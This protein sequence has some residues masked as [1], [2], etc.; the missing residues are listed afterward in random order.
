MRTASPRAIVVACAAFAAGAGG[1]ALFGLG[2]LDPPNGPI[3]PTYKTMSEVEPRTAINAANTPGDADSRFK[4]T[5]PGSYYLTGNLTG[6][7][8]KSGIEVTANCTIDLCG[9]ELTGVNGSLD[10]I[11]LVGEFRGTIRNGQVVGWGGNGIAGVDCNFCLF[12][13]LYIQGNA[14]H[15][16]WIGRDS[17]LS[18]VRSAENTDGIRVDTFC[19]IVDSI[20]SINRDRGIRAGTH[21]TISRCTARG[22]VN[23]GIAVTD[24]A[25]VSDCVSVANATGIEAQ[26]GIIR[27]NVCDGNPNQNI[28][29]GGAGGAIVRNNT[30]NNSADTG[31]YCAGGSTLIEANLL[32]SNRVGVV[33]LTDG[34][35][36]VIRNHA[37]KN[38]DYGYYSLGGNDLGQILKNP[39]HLFVSTNS[40]ANIERQ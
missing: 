25:N 17:I 39:G 1:F 14:A 38:T 8:G 32:K 12:E 31:I 11:L 18:R 4:I 5:K 9:F 27:D 28:F 13:D 21:A 3:T 2:P 35:N 6:V 23:S 19:T 29:I 7:S 30:C 24:G 15:G 16:I 22:N 36:I 33:V 20:V 40:W 10:G 26:G 37:L 34:G